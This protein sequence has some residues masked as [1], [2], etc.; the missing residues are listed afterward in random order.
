VN[1]IVLA[2]LS[3]LLATIAVY[4]WQQHRIRGLKSELDSLRTEAGQA[5]SRLTEVERTR[6]SQEQQLGAMREKA[7]RLD[8]ERER[9]A[10]LY[11][12]AHAN[13]EQLTTRIGEVEAAKGAAERDMNRLSA[14]LQVAKAQLEA[15]ARSDAG[16]KSR[17]GTT[18]SE[19]R[20]I[21]E[22]LTQVQAQHA[23]LEKEREGL[24]EQLQ[25][26]RTWVI[27]QTKF[28][29]QSVLTAARQLMEERG[30][31]LT[32]QSKREVDAVVSPFKEQ[33]HQ[34]RQRVDFIYAAENTER[35]QLREQIVQLTNLNQTVSMQAERLTK[36][37]TL[38]SKS[39]G[40]WGETI[41]HRILEDSGLR[42]GHE[43]WLQRS[44]DGPE[45][46]RLRPDAMIQLPEGRQLVVDSKVSNKAWAEYCGASDESAR[47]E[48]LQKHV[49]SLRTHIKGLSGKDYTRCPELHTVEFVLM[50][51]PVEAAL[52]TALAFD[53]T[54]YTEAYHS[55]II[56][57]SPSTLMAVVKL[58]EG[59]WT[60]Q[61]RKESA[62]E[63]AEAGRKL[64]DKLT[65]FA[66]T[67]LDVGTALSKARES[68][69]KAQGQL[70]TGH[71]NAI[72]LAE[73][74]RELGVTPTPGKTLPE[75]L[76]ELESE[77]D[78]A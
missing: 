64:Y 52:L 13:L 66:N 47:R 4:L 39:T 50:F 49:Q 5:A 27:E 7:Q 18:E 58:V 35:G 15:S 44:V 60:F 69:D 8:V 55:K 72:R 78:A 43:Y 51:V 62:D 45:G 74:M 32:E 71:G 31:A 30:K 19:R 53:Q 9:A 63:I 21:Q 24:R 25:S 2:T 42:E 67:F 11:G 77:S 34:F 28:F 76:L 56:L 1:V 59:I 17:L 12:Q 22:T 68:F 14:E 37:L 3:A 61:K 20:E 29:E 75:Q 40:D 33:L 41:L 54:L 36:A 38:N 16:L 46:E 6:S 65:T 26:Q 57:V 48:L 73:R 23:A 70:A 10:T